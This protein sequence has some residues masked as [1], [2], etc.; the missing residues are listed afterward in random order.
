MYRR[1]REVALVLS[2]VAIAVLVLRANQRRPSDLSW[3]DRAVLWVTA[4]VESAITGGVRAIARAWRN[5][6]W[7]VDARHESEELRAEND[8]LRGE[9]SRARLAEGRVARLEAMLALRAQVPAETL[10]ARVVGVDT[11]PFYRVVRV[12]LD[13]ARGEVKPNMVVV[14]PDGVVGRVGRVFDG[15]CEVLLAVESRLRHRRAGA[16]HRCA[17]RAQGR[18][19]HQP[20]RRRRL[21]RHHP[22]HA[23]RRR[24][25]RGR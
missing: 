15:Y 14:V 20:L 24:G 6:V 17:R 2:L 21:Q 7:L 25:A 12:R 9:L 13:R 4:P 22:Q 10:S 18:H 8:R 5:Y 3:F 23:A 11:S 1:L 16:A 19:R